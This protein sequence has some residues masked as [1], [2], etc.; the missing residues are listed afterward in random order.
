MSP[1]VTE[2]LELDLIWVVSLLGRWYGIV[3]VIVTNLVGICS[4][5][6][7]AESLLIVICGLTLLGLIIAGAQW[8][9][10]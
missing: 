3:R 5:R 2:S 7:E 1:F 9:R 8:L 10:G 6:L 4:R